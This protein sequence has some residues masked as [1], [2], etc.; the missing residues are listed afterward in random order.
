MKIFTFLIGYALADDLLVCYHSVTQGDMTFLLFL[1][2]QRQPV[3]EACDLL[4]KYDNV[5][6]WP[7]GENRG[8]AKSVNEAIVYAQ[9]AGADALLVVN[10]DVIAGPDDV[11]MLEEALSQEPSLAYVEAEGYVERTERRE[12]LGFSFALLNMLAFERIGFFDENFC[13]FYFEDADWKRRAK[14]AGMPSA[15]VHG[16]QAHHAGSKSLTHTPEEKAL[17]DAKFIPNRD[18]YL[19]KWGGDQGYEQYSRP[20]NDERCSLL[21]AREDMHNPYPHRPEGNR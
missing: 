15:I 12:P 16:T 7:Y 19:N 11:A 6:Y 5:H 17:F 18:Y 3:V 4:A 14:L 1:H 9:S 21:I 10:D 13:P 8:A 2:S 20:F